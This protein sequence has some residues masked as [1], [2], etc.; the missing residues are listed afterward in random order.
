[1]SE[2]RNYKQNFS[3]MPRPDLVAVPQWYHGYVLQTEEEEALQAIRANGEKAVAF[4]HGIEEDKWTHRYAEGKWSIKEMIQ[5]L[6]DAERI[7]AY[8]A[9]CIARGER[10]SLP[11]FDENGY[12]AASR[13]DNRKKD[14]LI[15]EFQTLRQSTSQ[16]FASFDGERLAATGTAN[17]ASISV[18]AIGFIIPG[19]V[20]HHL[21]VLK[22]R[23]L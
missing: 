5:H 14:D 23:Y 13:A 6:I 9:L 3:A 15:R 8:R 17:K 4:L 18:N 19:H 7:F 21:N 12:A 16:L 22:E 2:D 10:A 1:M 20:Q 11:G